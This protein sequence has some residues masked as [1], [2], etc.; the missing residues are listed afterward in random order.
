MPNRPRRTWANPNFPTI[1]ALEERRLLSHTLPTDHSHP[2][3]HAKNVAHSHAASH[4]NIAKAPAA[5]HAT[6]TVGVLSV[7][8]TAGNDII[9]LSIDAADSSRLDVTINGVTT[10]YA[11]S[12]LTGIRVT[13]GNGNDDIEVSELNGPLTLPVTLLGGS[14]NDTL[15]GG[16][17]ND[18]IQAGDGKNVLAGEAG[19]DT[20]IAGNGNDILLGGLGNDLLIAGNGQD[21]L[22][23]DGGADTLIAGTGN[24]NLQPGA[25]GIVIRRPTKHGK[26]A[27]PPLPPHGGSDSQG[28]PG[29]A[30]NANSENNPGSS[31]PHSHAHS[32]KEDSGD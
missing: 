7:T 17:G 31:D 3:V 13:G 23:G 2:A 12:K 21:T 8:G 19:N 6:G 28:G 16:S 5:S 18:Y 27:P 14:G 1:E 10:R 26:A 15:V 22:S 30:D 20:L 25:N 4:A 11:L 29:S 9:R 24:D 32:H